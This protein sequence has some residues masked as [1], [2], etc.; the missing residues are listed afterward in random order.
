M[1]RCDVILLQP[2]LLSTDT[3]PSTVILWSTERKQFIPLRDFL[4]YVHISS[5]GFGLWNWQGIFVFSGCAEFRIQYS[6]FFFGYQVDPVWFLMVETAHHAAKL[7]QV[8]VFQSFPMMLFLTFLEFFK[9]PFAPCHLASA[10]YDNTKRQ[11]PWGVACLFSLRHLSSGELHRAT[12]TSRQCWLW[13]TALLIFTYSAS[14][15]CLFLFKSER[16]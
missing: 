2:A 13:A 3:D 15:Y 14:T 4:I 5:F 12:E 16:D 8:L 7:R 1:K 11:L 6:Q 9:R 10:I